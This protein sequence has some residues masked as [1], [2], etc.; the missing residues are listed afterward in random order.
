MSPISLVM[1]LVCG[2]IPPPSFTGTVIKKERIPGK[3]HRTWLQRGPKQFDVFLEIVTDEGATVKVAGAVTE[4]KW[5]LLQLGRRYSF[6]GIENVRK[7]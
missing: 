4:E 6:N 7:L 3:I 2:H 5:G 1:G